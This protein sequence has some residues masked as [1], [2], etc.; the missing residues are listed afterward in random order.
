MGQYTKLKVGPVVFQWKNY[1]PAF[2]TFLFDEEDFFCRPDQLEDEDDR[3]EE[4][5]Y[6]T[7]CGES[8]RRMDALGYNLDFFAEVYDT[9]GDELERA[10]RETL[11][12]EFSLDTDGEMT[13]QDIQEAVTAH[14]SHFQPQSRTQDLID[15]VEFVR[16][17]LASNF[18]IPQFREP[19]RLR[20]GDRV[21]EVPF[22]QAIR[23]HGEPDLADFESLQMFLLDRARLFRPSVVKLSCFFDEG[24]LFEYP[25]VV[26]LMYCRLLLEAVA[27]GE[28]IVLDLADVV[29]SPDEARE[30]HEGMEP[31]ITRKVHL[32]NR[33][34]RVLSDNE[35]DILERYAKAQG[36]SLVLELGR[37]QP[38][39]EKGKVLEELMTAAFTSHPKLTVVEKRY[40]TGDEEIDLI[41][42]NGLEGGFWTGLGSPLIFVECKNWTRNIG[43]RELRDFEVKLQNHYPLVKLGLLVAPGGFSRECAGELKRMSRD[44]YTIATVDLSDIRRFFDGDRPLPDWLET[45]ICRPV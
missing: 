26:S 18:D 42:K 24:Y 29:E 12:E 30:L 9:F 25:E 41:V 23:W 16:E 19:R 4:L 28:E 40:S 20:L 17:C 15:F 6:R 11:Q 13:A 43:V 7:R 27:E 35:A 22:D 8:K 3:F 33:V 36:R 5:G 45:V 1:V 21:V 38:A 37:T 31:G 44:N 34:F 10:L 2:L 32:Y 14:L 39:N